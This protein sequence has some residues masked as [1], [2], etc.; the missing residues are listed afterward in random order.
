M[1]EQLILS[2]QNSCSCC[3]HYYPLRCCPYLTAQS[4][5]SGKKYASQSRR[6]C[7]RYCA[8][9]KLRNSLLTHKFSTIKTWLREV[10]GA[11]LAWELEC[12]WRQYWATIQAIYAPSG[13]P[14]VTSDSIEQHLI[15]LTY[16]PSFTQ[17]EWP[18]ICL[19]MPMP[20]QFPLKSPPSTPKTLTKILTSN[21]PRKNPSFIADYGFIDCP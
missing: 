5:S 4:K 8:R 20:H 13:G 15:P 17:I 18:L 3:R 7:L 14:D 9:E 12:Y 10:S 16:P 1:S 19:Q 21:P 6:T 11:H 2:G